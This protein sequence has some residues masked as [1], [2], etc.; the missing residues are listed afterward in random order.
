M[1]DKFLKP[2]APP[3][4]ARLIAE[5]NAELSGN[6]TPIDQ[7]S[8]SLRIK[9]RFADLYEQCFDVRPFLEAMLTGEIGRDWGLEQKGFRLVHFASDKIWVYSLAA[10][11]GCFMY[12]EKKVEG[13]AAHFTRYPERYDIRPLK[14]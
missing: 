14:L 4:A 12:E 11:S 8:A 10:G 6:T 3:D 9:A 1:F 7:A 2:L 13:G 5:L